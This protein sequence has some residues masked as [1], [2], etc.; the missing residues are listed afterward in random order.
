MN[1]KYIE[2]WNWFTKNESAINR[3]IEKNANDFAFDIYAELTK[4][5]PELHFEI[6]F[7]RKNGKREFIISA[8]GIKEI[9]PEVIALAEVAPNYEDWIIT[10]FRPRTYQRNQVTE[11]D[12][13]FL[14]YEDIYFSYIKKENRL[15]MNVY[16]KNYDGVDNR[17]VHAYFILLDT[18]IGEYDAV[19]FISNTS[20]FPLEP[21]T[22]IFPITNIIELIDGLSV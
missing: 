3:G 16:I 4:V 18:L 5:H 17:Y 2:F 1:N 8:D 9:F 13:I 12:G 22:D 11:M 7:E 20:V 21:L 10:P 14:S 15:D 6:P 19:T